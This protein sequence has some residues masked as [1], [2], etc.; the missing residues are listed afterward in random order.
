[1]LFDLNNNWVGEVDKLTQKQTRMLATKIQRNK[2]FKQVKNISKKVDKPREHLML[3]TNSSLKS[4]MEQKLSSS[5]FRWLNEQLYTQHSS[6]ALKL[7]TESPELFSVYHE[8]FN[9]QTQ[10]WPVNPLDRIIS[11]LNTLPADLLVA[12]LGC[13]EARLSLEVDQKV[14]SFDLVAVN[15]RVIACDM[16]NLPIETA[17]VHIAVFCLSLMGTNVLEFL[18]EAR[19][20]L[21]HRGNLIIAEIFSRFEDIDKFISSVEELNFKIVSRDNLTDMFVL[22]K[23]RR[24]KIRSISTHKIETDLFSLK[25]CLYKKR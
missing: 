19:R 25:P 6:G 4:R 17:T 8:G 24:K 12:D 9:L 22:I 11:H 15:S 21:K 23:F 1:M 14:L 20:V 2:Q 7:F 10:K 5:K 16:R 18:L 13:G 3:N